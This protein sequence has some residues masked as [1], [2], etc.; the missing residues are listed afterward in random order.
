MSGV[1]KVT[2]LYADDRLICEEPDSLT[3]PASSIELG[4][5]DLF[6]PN[7]VYLN[8]EIVPVNHRTN[9]INCGAPVRQ[10]GSC[11]YCGTRNRRWNV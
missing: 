3:I 5:S 8:P 2:R 1:S 4:L 6:M 7:S 9:C 10:D 11:E